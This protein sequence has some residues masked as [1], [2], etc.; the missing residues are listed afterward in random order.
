MYIVLG[1]PKVDNTL[2]PEKR[3]PVKSNGHQTAGAI[4]EDWVNAK[5]DSKSKVESGYL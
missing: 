4:K 3:Q 1:S 2:H 5:Q